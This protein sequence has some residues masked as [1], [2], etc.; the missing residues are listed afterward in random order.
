M[1]IDTCV[2]V[3]LCKECFQYE[4]I[5]KEEMEEVET[6][7][8]HSGPKQE[9]KEEEVEPPWRHSGLQEVKEEVEPPWRQQ[10][11]SA[12]RPS[13]S[14]SWGERS[15]VIEVMKPEQPAYPP[16]GWKKRKFL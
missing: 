13:S 15:P 4:A 2:D 3:A 9:V 7:W 14:S 1:C 12:S 11:T 16:P 10:K 5:E 8:R 6:P